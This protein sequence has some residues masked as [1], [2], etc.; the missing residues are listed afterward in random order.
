MKICVSYY[1]E[2]GNIRENNEDSILVY[3]E[4]FSSSNFESPILKNL[5][6]EEGF[7]SVAD[8]IGGHAGG[9][10]ASNLVLSYLNGQKG[11]SHEKLMEFFKGAHNELNSVI[12]NRP[13]L[14]GMGTVL[15]GIYVKKDK[16]VVFNIGDSRTYF[17]R[18]KLIRMTDDNSFVWE[19]MKNEKFSGEEEMHEWIRNHPRKNII[20]S[21]LIGGLKEF[22]CQLKDLEIKKGDKFFIVSD[23]VWEELTFKDMEGALHKELKSGSQEILEKCRIKGTDNLSF[24]IVEIME[25]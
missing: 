23:G 7:F 16:A 24:I 10:I 25:I 5:D 1:T 13:D 4:V 9:E 8:G 15:T 17:M 12:I 2:K 20:L 14:L 11:D 18:E 22:E 6:I 19:L 3:D 21:A